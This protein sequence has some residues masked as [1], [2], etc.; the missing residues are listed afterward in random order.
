M[1]ML[2]D[3]ALPTTFAGYADFAIKCEQE[4]LLNKQRGRAYRDIPASYDQNGTIY[5][6]PVT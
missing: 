4:I 3:S 1:E 2:P 6:K 5:D